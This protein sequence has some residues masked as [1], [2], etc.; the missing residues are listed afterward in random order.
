VKKLIL[1][2][3]IAAIGYAAYRQYS[4]NQAE[5]ELWNEATRDLDLR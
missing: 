1:I 4:A 5:Q 2:G 3:A